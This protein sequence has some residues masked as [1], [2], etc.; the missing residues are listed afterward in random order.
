MNIHIDKL[1]FNSLSGLCH[2][3]IKCLNC[4]KNTS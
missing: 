1:N 2:V 4:L 3:R